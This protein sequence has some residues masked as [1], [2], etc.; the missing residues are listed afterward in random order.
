MALL[1]KSIKL[2]IGTEKL[3]TKSKT[4]CIIINVKLRKGTKRKKN[5]ISIVLNSFDRCWVRCKIKLSIRS[6]NPIG[7]G[8]KFKPCGVWVQI[9]LGAFKR[10]TALRS[11]VT[12][13]NAF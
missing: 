2:R 8:N 13:V 3:L 12:S 11:R 10:T 6:H 4:W 1:F 7:R 5:R 9:P